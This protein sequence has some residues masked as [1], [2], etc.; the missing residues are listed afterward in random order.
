MRRR[1]RKALS[2][3]HAMPADCRGVQQR[4]LKALLDLNRESHFSRDH[5]LVTAQSVEDLRKAVPVSDY[6]RFRPY[7]DLMKA[8]D[9]RGDLCKMGEVWRCGG[10][11]V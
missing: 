3:F 4:T 11:E 9:H 2:E 6:E 10:V 1:L 7:I 8:G 5:G